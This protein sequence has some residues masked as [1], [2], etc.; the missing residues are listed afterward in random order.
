M[1]VGL[2]IFSPRHGVERRWIKRTDLRQARTWVKTGEGR[3]I[4]FRQTRQIHKQV[5]AVLSRLES[6]AVFSAMSG[7]G[8]E[9]RLVAQCEA[10]RP[11]D[12]TRQIKTRAVRKSLCNTP[13]TSSAIA[14]RIEQASQKIEKR[15]RTSRSWYE[16]VSVERVCKVMPDTVRNCARQITRRRARPGR[17]KHVERPCGRV[18]NGQGLGHGVKWTL[19]RYAGE[20][21]QVPTHLETPRDTVA[22]GEKLQIQDR[23][24]ITLK[25]MKCGDK[26][27]S[28]ATMLDQIRGI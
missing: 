27:G 12:R 2:H 22:K 3:F 25:Q 15:S 26:N 21:S 7:N 14:E 17:M 18:R 8:V 4:S 20:S 19:E 10:F 5:E 6:G 24:C 1:H 16:E 23:E 28:I 11:T 13:K 9:A